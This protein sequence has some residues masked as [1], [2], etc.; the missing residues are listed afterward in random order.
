M[1]GKFIGHERG[2]YIEPPELLCAA[3]DDSLMNA[4]TCIIG[5]SSSVRLSTLGT[6]GVFFSGFRDGR[7]RFLKTHR[8]PAANVNI[9]KEFEMLD[10]LYG[11]LLHPLFFSVQCDSR[12]QAFLEM[13]YIEQ[14]CCVSYMPNHV[15]GVLDGVF[16]RLEHQNHVTLNYNSDGLC[17]LIVPAIEALSAARVMDADMAK[18]CLDSARRF[19]DYADSMPM[20]CHGDLS[21]DNIR[22]HDGGMVLIDW[23]DA[24]VCPKHYDILYWLTF[25]SQRCYYTST[26]L[27]NVGVPR[28]YGIDIMVVIVLLKSYLSFLN[29]SYARFKM[30]ISDRIREIVSIL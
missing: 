16:K 14:G 12:E 21:N 15:I 11:S 19:H 2:G 8:L 5:L 24:I 6:S 3:S 27:S 17:A 28:Q 20:I 18:I 1:L 29:G 4:V 9:R 22:V 30:S 10:H 23:E 25:M 7:R 13:D 26:L